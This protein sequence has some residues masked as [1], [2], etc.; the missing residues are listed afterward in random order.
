[1]ITYHVSHFFDTTFF[2]CIYFIMNL[3]EFLNIGYYMDLKSIYII[4][5]SFESFYTVLSYSAENIYLL[6]SDFQLICDILV[7][8]NTIRHIFKQTILIILS[9]LVFRIMVSETICYHITVTIEGNSG[10]SCRQRCCPL[11]YYQILGY[12]IPAY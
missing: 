11:G 12:G 1:M 10:D 5:V 9:K 4:F 2:A 8:Y 3:F 6:Y 7:S